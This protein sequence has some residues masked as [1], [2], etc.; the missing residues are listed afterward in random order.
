MRAGIVQSSCVSEIWPENLLP[1]DVFS[2]LQTQWRIGM[3]GPTGL[4]YGVLPVVLD[5]KQ[6]EPPQRAEIFAD[7][8]I[9]EAEALR[10]F[11]EK[12]GR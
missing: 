11:A 3:S 12:N 5:I 9:M 2:A 7:V 1:F 10:F 8:Q 4:D 6:I